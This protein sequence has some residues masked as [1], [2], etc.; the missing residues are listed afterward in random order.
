MKKDSERN[1]AEQRE[2]QKEVEIEKLKMT[3]RLAEAVKTINF[4]KTQAIKEAQK[5]D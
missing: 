3:N 4:L 1:L 2:D 5:W